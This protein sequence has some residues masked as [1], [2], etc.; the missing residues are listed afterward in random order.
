MGNVAWTLEDAEIVR[1]LYYSRVS[2]SEIGARLGRSRNSIAGL[3]SRM[4]FERG[5][6]PER[7]KKAVA[8]IN[9]VEIEEPVEEIVVESEPKDKTK[10]LIELEPHDCRWPIGDSDFRFCG[11]IAVEGRPYCLEH[12]Q[13]AYVPRRPPEIKD[14]R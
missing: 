4:E 10:S 6:A 9:V 7:K 14:K 8:K 11:E 3:C 12:C 1:K 2:F 5:P 13:L